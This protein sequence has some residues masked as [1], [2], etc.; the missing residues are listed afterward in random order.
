M[1]VG[2]KYSA[3]TKQ[4]G[5]L[6]RVRI[7]RK[8]NREVLGMAVRES[9]GNMTKQHK[10]MTDGSWQRWDGKQQH[11]TGIRARTGGADQRQSCAATRC[12]CGER[13]KIN[14]QLVK[15][16]NGEGRKK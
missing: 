12:G 15:G 1:H 3:S 6:E 8:L 11:E 14:I 2:S 9:I 10:H 7:I 5:A 13:R 16:S 4:E